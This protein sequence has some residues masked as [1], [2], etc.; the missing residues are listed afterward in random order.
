MA[1]ASLTADIG[2]W[3]QPPPLGSTKSS[4]AT[5]SSAFSSSLYRNHLLIPKRD[6]KKLTG[7]FFVAK[8]LNESLAITS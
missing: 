2:P 1:K 3:K 7:P 5:R 6:I 4:Q 8:V